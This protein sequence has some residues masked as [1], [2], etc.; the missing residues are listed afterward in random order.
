M[1]PAN[2]LLQK[3]EGGSVNEKTK[4][5]DIVLHPASL[6]LPK[7]TDF[8]L[9]KQ[10]DGGLGQTC[11]GMVIGTPS[12]MAPEQAN[13]Q[14]REV[15]PAAD[16]Y[17]LGAI[18]YELLTGRPPFKAATQLDTLRQVLAD[19]PVPLSRF[20]LK[21]PGDL[22]TI[23][24]KCL[25]K[26]PHK[27]YASALALAEDLERFLAGQPI[28][29]RRAGLLER[30]GRWCRRQ[31]VLALVTGLAV[32]AFLGVIGISICFGVSQYRA[33]ARLSIALEEARNQRRQADELA[34]SLSVDHA[35]T[36]CEQGDVSQGLLLLAWSL[37]KATQAD[38]R[39]LQP[40]IRANLAAWREQ[41]HPLLMCLPEEQQINTL[42]FNLDAKQAATGGSDSTVR[43]WDLQSGSMIRTLRHDTPVL[44]VLF[45]PGGSSLLTVTAEAVQLWDKTFSNPRRIAAK[46]S[47]SFVTAAL[48]ADNS[49]LVTGTEAGSL[50]VWDVA[51]GTCRVT[52]SCHTGRIQSV[53]FSPDSA[54]IVTGGADQTARLW[55]AT[56]LG[57]IGAP[58]LHDAAVLCVAFS[59]DGQTI[60]TGSR[61]WK[62]RLWDPAT[63]KLRFSPLI[64]KD[65][66]TDLA[67][68]PN[69][70]LLLTGCLDGQARL[71]ETATGQQL[72]GSLP[73]AAEVRAVAFSP[74]GNSVLTGGQGGVARLWK[75][76]P[77]HEQRARFM[78]PN[79]LATLAFGP[80]AGILA[81]GGDDPAVRLWNGESGQLLR[82]LLPAHEDNVRA[83]AFTPDGKLLLSGGG[84]HQVRLWE[85]ATGRL[86][87]I[88]WQ[89]DRPVSS[90][91]IS[92]DS[93]I[94]L[95]GM[96]DGNVEAG[97]ITSGK[98]L[99]KIV[100][101]QGPVR[102]LALSPDGKTFLTSGDQCA[103]LWMTDTR[104]PLG[105]PLRH[106]GT[107]GPV[108]FSPDGQ[109]IFTGGGDKIV[110][111]WKAGTGEA[112]HPAISAP[113]PIRTIA[114]SPDGR[115]LLIGCWNGSSRLWDVA[116]RKPLGATEYDYGPVL[117]AAFA[118]DGSQILIAGE[119]KT[120]RRWQ[121]PR[122]IDGG[123]MQILLWTQVLTGLEL[124]APGETMILDV[125]SWKQRA[126]R[127]RALGW[128][129]N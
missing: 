47:E 44:R 6:I 129:P 32:T 24:M 69:G 77:I 107:V 101:H 22:N 58:L 57:A 54:R 74:D 117:A 91:A 87:G 71:W 97:E 103:R 56:R 12:Y 112:L 15:G 45:T 70:K 38:V 50:E 26:E 72:R 93:Q 33:A 78:H 52:I 25:Q 4:Q 16:I 43:I 90:L 98:S 51:S 106:Q 63:G 42:A 114:L 116:T 40:V 3:D 1:K 121:V 36:L 19:E 29:A 105:A 96:R 7:I 95:V 126:E 66:V 100:A 92:P 68:S 73:H 23:C 104:Q 119:D 20:H 53:A 21:V 88:R 118:R 30:M 46:H 110:R 37:E 94:F 82:T 67:F 5:S 17:A 10:L 34:V 79:W 76:V 55:E 123:S 8:G 108:A 89:G 80:E 27:R 14:V 85:V 128:P 39:G 61:D 59:P 83:L 111:S 124:D 81:A 9:A 2:I 125:Q 99:G 11:S 127:L 18:L 86:I 109:T 102:S 113:S 65:P 28:R 64:H 31:P 122:P 13:S 48:S 84:D 60:A 35:L 120:I 62:V 75:V 115:T 41:L 49:T